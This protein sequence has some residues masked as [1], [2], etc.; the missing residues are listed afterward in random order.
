MLKFILPNKFNVIAFKKYPN[1]IN[2]RFLWNA[3]KLLLSRYSFLFDIW[4]KHVVACQQ[5]YTFVVS[6]NVNVFVCIFAVA[7]IVLFTSMNAP[8]IKSKHS[9]NPLFLWIF[10]FQ[11]KIEY[12]CLVDRCIDVYVYVYACVREYV[13]A[14][15]LYG[16]A[17]I[18]NT[19]I[20]S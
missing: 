15:I 5:P 11:C 6:W 8:Q 10:S 12:L 7:G 18:S 9:T 1:K 16:I 19:L 17:W 20:N 2:P 14:S 4:Q 3:N 13:Y